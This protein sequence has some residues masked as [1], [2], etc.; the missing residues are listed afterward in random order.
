MF[1]RWVY[2]STTW[3]LK[4]WFGFGK[5]CATVNKYGLWRAWGKNKLSFDDKQCDYVYRGL[6]YKEGQCDYVY[7]GLKEAR[8]CIRAKF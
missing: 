1:L 2:I 4:H 8:L 7:Q 3:E 5:T 6:S